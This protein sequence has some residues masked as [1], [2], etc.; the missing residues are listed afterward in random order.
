MLRILLGGLFV[1]IDAGSKQYQRVERT[2][3]DGTIRSHETGWQL[4]LVPDEIGH[5]IIG[6]AFLSLAKTAQGPLRTWL[7][8]LGWW[9]LLM[10]L[11]AIFG[12]RI[13]QVVITEITEYGSRSTTRPG[14]VGG[15]LVPALGALWAIA[16][17]A[18]GWCLAKLCRTHNLLRGAQLWTRYAW[19]VSALAVVYLA[20]GAFFIVR[21]FAHPE[22]PIFGAIPNLAQT[23][24]AFAVLG[25]VTMIT[26]VV[27]WLHACLGTRAEALATPRSSTATV[28]G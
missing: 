24:A 2:A 12:H 19:L 21:W 1:V 11:M 10:I 8:A 5:L 26:L 14:W 25:V 20:Y 6:L 3:S 7:K 17:V 23:F 27:V 18:A 15:Y 4:D 9:Q 22:E 28:S 16:E 13:N